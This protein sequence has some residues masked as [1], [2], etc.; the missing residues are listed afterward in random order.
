MGSTEAGVDAR[1]CSSWLEFV[2]QVLGQGGGSAWR[3]MGVRRTVQAFFPKQTVEPEESAQWGGSGS[4]QWLGQCACRRS[5]LHSRKSSVKGLSP[6]QV[7]GTPQSSA[8]CWVF[9][10]TPPRTLLP[11]LSGFLGPGE[12]LPLTDSPEG[13]ILFPQFHDVL[14]RLLISGLSRR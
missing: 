9:A 8:A 5:G 1:W 6:L 2:L 4:E 14:T 11:V 13:A 10:W 7:G 3:G 12:L